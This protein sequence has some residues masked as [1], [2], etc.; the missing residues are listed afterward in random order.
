MKSIAPDSEH[1]PVGARGGGDKLLYRPA[2]WGGYAIL[3]SLFLILRFIVF[4]DQWPT[5]RDVR[6][7]IP[8]A[9]IGTV[10]LIVSSIAIFQA[11][12]AERS[13]R[14]Q[15]ARRWM[16]LTLLFGIGFTVFQVGEFRH[17][18]SHRL[19]PAPFSNALHDRADLY[20]LS[21]VHQRL[22]QLATV[23]NTSKVRQNQLGEQLRNL[24]DERRSDRSRLEAELRRL[25][26]EE[27][28][29]GERLTVINRLLAS[30]ARWTSTVVATT[31]D[32]AIQ[33]RAIAA[34]AYDIHPHRAYSAAHQQFRHFEAERLGESLAEAQKGLSAAQA[35]AK[36]GSEPVKF[37]LA[38]VAELRA[39]QHELQSQLKSHLRQTLAAEELE[40]LPEQPSDPKRTAFEN[41]LAEVQ[42]R[43]DDRN[44][45]LTAAATL[46]TEAED[47]ASQLSQEL[48]N[49]S[50][51]QATIAEIDSG[52][53]LNRQYEWLQL[54]VC[55]PGGSAWSWT[56]FLLTILHTTH[57]AFLLIAVFVL[58]MV[59][60]QSLGGRASKTEQTARNWHSMVIVWVLL[61]VL[62]YLI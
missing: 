8:W 40:D 45:K 6:V 44:A 60:R 41:Q 47:R 49:I 61:F 12:R 20:F 2:L 51:R 56:Y 43:L 31:T 38:C 34:L 39:E 32:L 58:A 48:S 3:L 59:S 15:L 27:S 35:S 57:L 7:E 33:K 1:Q 46:V 9:A 30:E 5:Q 54:P 26:A 50:A 18:W 10:T 21:A 52:I 25:Q 22:M 37:L 13:H 28:Q 4:G 19:I 11:E 24:S 16:L 17:R 29:R 14:M 55:I 36:V 23:I 42:K 53:G 62:F